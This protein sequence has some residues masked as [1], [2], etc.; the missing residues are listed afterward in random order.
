[1]LALNFDPFPILQSERLSF[2]SLEESDVHEVYNLR[3]NA[4]VMRYIPRPLAKT[5]DDALEHIRSVQKII[6]NK[7]GINWA[8]QIKGS[9]KLIGIAGFYR[10][11]PE[12]FRGELGYILAPEYHNQ[13]Y[14]TEAVKTLL[15]YAF[16]ILNFHSIEA[17]IDPD[18]VASERVL[19]KSGFVKEAHLKE[20]HWWDGAFLDTVIY[21]LLKSNFNPLGNDIE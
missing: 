1:M 16:N 3:S 6:H 2:R 19:L 15:N 8:I 11:Q 12:N 10:L 14:I 7:E 9:S 20:N 18:N 5:T 4:E 17:I 13:G 21:S